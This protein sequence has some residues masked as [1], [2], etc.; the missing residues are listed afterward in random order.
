[1]SK[2]AGQPPSLTKRPRS[3]RGTKNTAEK[4]V[5]TATDDTTAVQPVAP[6]EVSSQSQTSEP[7]IGEKWG[8][9]PSPE[10]QAELAQRLQEWEQDHDHGNRSG[11][12]AQSKLTGADVYWLAALAAGAGDVVVGTQQLKEPFVGLST[13]HLEG[14]NLAHTHL[15]GAS[16]S[17]AH[18][19]GAI[20]V[21]AQLEGANLIRAQ[22]EG[23][24][25]REVHLKGA[26]LSAAQLKGVFLLWAQLEGTDLSQAHLE[27]A[28]LRNTRLE[29][30]FLVDAQLKGADLSYTHLEGAF[31]RGAQLQAVNLT[32]ANLSGA[33]LREAT[34]DRDTKLVEAVFD[35]TLRVADVAWNGVS[36]VRVDWQ[37]IPR[38]GDEAAAHQ[39]PVSSIESISMQRAENYQAAARA[40][41]QLAI[42]LRSQGITDAA[43]RFTYRALIMQRKA[44]WL[45]SKLPMTGFTEALARLKTL[46]LPQMWQGAVKT[47]RSLV[48]QAWKERGQ[49]TPRQ[50]LRSLNQWARPQARRGWQRLR[51]ITPKS[52]LNRLWNL[53]AWGLGL[54]FLLVILAVLM[55]VAH[56]WGALLLLLL[57]VL[58]VGIFSQRRGR[59]LLAYL[60]SGFLATLTGYGFRMERIVLWYVLLISGFAA[61]YYSVGVKQPRDISIAEALIVSVTAFHGRVFTNPFMP[62]IPDAQVIIT[63]IEAVVGLIIEGVF[64]AM[65][66][67]RFFNR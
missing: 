61:A 36:L 59:K 51:T 37:R 31:L 48:L 28:H 1:M 47:G 20:L 12:L 32:G 33:D 39:V 49:Y 10:R 23:T 66:T 6:L 63:A 43:D 46:T 53:P 65:L 52:W 24:D 19:E 17:H 18:L 4:P 44:L 29:G 16:L 7:P 15:E 27:E 56:W 14:A 22:L 8:E 25:L 34:L 54:G 26:N 45:E 67:Q 35:S 55:S 2:P 58:V 64:I 57:M 11:P 50:M 62:N 42:S 41:R 13:L 5:A 9:F 38:L 40:Y 60:F 30:A 21:G 3:A